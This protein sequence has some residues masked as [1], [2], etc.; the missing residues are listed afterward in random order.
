MLA[1]RSSGSGVRRRAGHESFNMDAALQAHV[2]RSAFAIRA[3]PHRAWREQH[4]L[5]SRHQKDTGRIGGTGSERVHVSGRTGGRVTR[6]PWQGQETRAG[7]RDRHPQ[8][9]RDLHRRAPHPCKCRR[10]PHRHGGGPVPDRHGRAIDGGARGGGNAGR[11]GQARPL[12]DL[13]LDDAGRHRRRRDLLLGGAPLQGPHQVGLAILALPDAGR[14][15]RGLFSQPRR[16]ERL[17]RPLR[18]RREGHR[19]GNRRHG[20]HGRGALHLHQRHLRHRLEHRPPGP[21]LHRRNRLRR[22]GRNQRPSRHH[23]RRVPGADL[24]RGDAGALA[25]PD[26]A[27][28]LRRLA[29]ALRLLAG[30]P[31]QRHGAMA[32]ADVRPLASA[33]G[34]NADLRAPAARDRA[35]VRAACQ[36]HFAGCGT[37]T[38]RHRDPQ[39]VPGPAHPHRRRDHGRDH[40]AWRRADRLDRRRRDSGLSLRPEGVAAGDPDSSSPWPERRSSCRCSSCS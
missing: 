32:G 10:V 22:A 38:R 1:L 35:G 29:A 34:R 12:A 6:P 30:L 17:H 9:A 20:G 28:A 19:S 14:A 37:A 23:A 40:D 11:P 25:D 5:H 3:Y 16:Q 33:L 31:R 27:A 4:D 21:R 39:P 15:R 24:H 36:R 2:A 18:S 13:H 26:R 7:R 8:S